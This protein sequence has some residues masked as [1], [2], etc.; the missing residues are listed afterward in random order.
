MHRELPVLW[1]LKHSQSPIA[2]EVPSI[3]DVINP[4]PHGEQGVLASP[5]CARGLV[6]IT[7]QELVDLVGQ[8]LGSSNVLLDEVRVDGRRNVGKV[9]GEDQRFIVHC[10]QS[11]DPIWPNDSCV[12]L[13]ARQPDAAWN[14]EETDARTG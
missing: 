8:R 9:V 7:T 1:G 13:D 4:N 12:A 14:R 3:P 5:R 10:R 11:V 2:S 6:H